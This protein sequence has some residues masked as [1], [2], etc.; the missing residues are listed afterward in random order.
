MDNFEMYDRSQD[1]SI[2]GRLLYSQADKPRFVVT[3]EKAPY[4]I[5]STGTVYSTELWQLDAIF[6]EFQQMVLRVQEYE[7]EIPDVFDLRPLSS[8]RV[9]LKIR[10]IKPAQF[11]YVTDIDD[12]EE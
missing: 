6:T 2:Y 1:T 12:D 4:L 3:E 10:N 9:T 8:Q 7:E 5:Q 11:Y